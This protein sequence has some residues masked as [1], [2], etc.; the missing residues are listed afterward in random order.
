MEC[1]RGHCSVPLRRSSFH[2]DYSACS[3]FFSSSAPCLFT[4]PVVATCI[5]RPQASSAPSHPRFS[6]FLAS[7]FPSS[8]P[9]K[10]C[11][12][13]SLVWPCSVEALAVFFSS[14]IH[15][16]LILGCLLSFPPASLSSKQ[17]TTI[18]SPLRRHL[19]SQLPRSPLSPPSSVCRPLCWTL[20]DATLTNSAPAP[21]IIVVLDHAAPFAHLGW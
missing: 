8:R 17:A 21:A 1:S 5:S 6:P 12:F 10:H 20:A 14:S 19:L 9:S 7:P 2:L 15:I 16:V 3:S 18:S 13:L 4:Q 11:V